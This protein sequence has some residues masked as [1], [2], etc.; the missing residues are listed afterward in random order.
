MC[1][2][3]RVEAHR[4]VYSVLREADYF[5]KSWIA[6]HTCNNRSCINPNH[7]IPG[8]KTDNARDARNY[9]R[10]V[11]LSEEQVREIIKNFLEITEWPF[12]SKKSFA[13]KWAERYG[14]SKHT[15]HNIVFR[16]LRW[17]D[18]LKEYGL[19]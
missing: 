8:D 19:L 5:D 17:K 11:K 18:I 7:I 14:V 3:D 13:E 6:R 16:R 9:S 10:A 15:I 1:I 12:G 2:R 4:W